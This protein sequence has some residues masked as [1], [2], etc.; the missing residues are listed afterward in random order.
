[1]TITNKHVGWAIVITVLAS[2]WIAGL[3]VPFHPLTPGYPTFWEGMA[4]VEI[5]VTVLAVFIGFLFLTL[6]WIVGEVKFEWH[7]NL[8]KRKKKALP[9]HSD[10]LKLGTL[11]Q[12]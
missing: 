1:M 9:S 8:P 6:A 5:I 3:F 10:F 4:R 7:I 11:D 2:P 12:D